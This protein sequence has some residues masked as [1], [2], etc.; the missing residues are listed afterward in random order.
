[1][2]NTHCLWQR[3]DKMNTKD[4][5]H[6]SLLH[7]LVGVFAI[8]WANHFR[9]HNVISMTV[10]MASTSLHWVVHYYASVHQSSLMFDQPVYRKHYLTM[11]QR[12]TCTLSRTWSVCVFVTRTFR[13]TMIN[14][15][16][17]C[18]GTP[19]RFQIGHNLYSVI[20]CMLRPQSGC[21]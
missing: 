10:L 13:Q 9:Y 5:N 1:M 16:L 18:V 8:Q 20:L 15:T 7:R 2:C 14:L 19:S 4:S 21:S 11:N 17:A 6:S 3:M 12:R